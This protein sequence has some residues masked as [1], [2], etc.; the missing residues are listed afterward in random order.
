M[1]RGKT[2]TQSDRTDRWD[3][4]HHRNSLSTFENRNCLLDVVQEN[5]WGQKS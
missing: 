4:L 2:T 3:E 5:G 1:V